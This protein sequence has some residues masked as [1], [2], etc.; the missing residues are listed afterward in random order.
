MAVRVRIRIRPRE[1]SSHTEVAAL[2]NSGFETE[3]PQ[4][5][6]PTALARQLGL[7]PPPPSSY[8]VELGTAGGPVRNYLV[9][10]AL[11][12]HLVV[13]DKVR[14]PVICDAIL[15]HIEEEV[16]INDKLGEELGIMI[17]GLGSGRW[18]L[19]DEPQAV[20]RYSE[21]PQYFH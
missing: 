2:V 4:L 19:I 12:I 8:L 15:S 1:S 17:I 21:K 18:R 10:N 11:E 13:E 3:K 6:I 20:V 5:L 9:P 16:I 7:W 14:G